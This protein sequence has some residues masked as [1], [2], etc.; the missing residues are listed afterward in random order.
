MLEINELIK[1]TM[2]KEIFN[3]SEL[4]NKSA[5]LVLS[6]IKTKLV[7][8]RENITAEIQNKVLKKIASDRSKS[9]EI[10]KEAQREDLLEKEVAEYEVCKKILDDLSNYLPKMMTEDEIKQKIET[11]IKSNDKVNI[12]IVMKEFK[13]LNADRAMVSK[14]AQE[15]LKK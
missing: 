2:K 10:Y 5:R 7:D 11:I 12:G 1:S 15:M 3:G 8:F 14:L 6:E 13:E 4:E 9:I